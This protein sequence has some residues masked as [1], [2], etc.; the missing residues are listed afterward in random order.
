MGHQGHCVIVNDLFHNLPENEMFGHPTRNAF[1][2]VAPNCR[3]LNDDTY[4][5]Y[6]HLV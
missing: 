4:L 2:L 1:A 5:L 6:G 3:F